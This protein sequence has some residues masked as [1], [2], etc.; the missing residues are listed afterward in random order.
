[1]LFVCTGVLSVATALS[2]AGRWSWFCELLVN[3]RTHFALA[4]TLAVLV[5]ILLRRWLL[6]LA[7]LAGLVLNAWPLAGLSGTPAA[8]SADGRAVRLVAFNVNVG[9]ADMPRVARYLDSLAPDVV[10]LEELPAAHAQRLFELLPA[11]PNHFFAPGLSAGGVAILS[12]W[13]LADPQVITRDGVQLAARADVDIGD[14][15]LRLYGIHLF[16]PLVARSADYRNAQIEALGRELAECR[17]ACVAAGD[18]NTTPWSSHFRDLVATPGI[19]DCSRGF[20]WL[21]TWPAALPAWLRIRIDHCLASASVAVT[22]ARVGEAAGSDHLATIN[23]L[24]V[25][26]TPSNDP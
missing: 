15:R 23:D 21:P 25:A 24:S 2:Y 6:A 8:A 1:M 9:N 14:R 18:F 7:A 16:W 22:G 12:R 17:G 20:G 26:S 19:H 13:P 11:L 10:V 4:F 3:F 5:A